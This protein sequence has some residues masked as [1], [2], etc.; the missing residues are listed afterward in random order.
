MTG[1]D[2]DEWKLLAETDPALFEARRTQ[3]LQELI[4]QCPADRRRRLAGLQ[5]RIDAQR[6][7]YR[8]PLA[9]SRWLYGLMWDSCVGDQGLLASLGCPQGQAVPR[10]AAPAAVVLPFRK[11][12]IPR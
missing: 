8:H 12:V 6:H 11:A 3:V 9:A 7:K 2:F 1:F 5:W 10:A 4:A